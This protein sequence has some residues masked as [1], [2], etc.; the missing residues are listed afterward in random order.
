MFSPSPAGENEA[1]PFEIMLKCRNKRIEIQQVMLA[2]GV[3]SPLNCIQS[4]T[5]NKTS[6]GVGFSLHS[7]YL[8][9]A[10]FSACLGRGLQMPQC[11][12]NGL[13]SSLNRFVK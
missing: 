2:D 4:K 6:E 10:Y 5:L 12:S 7:L 11:T 1:L 3:K 8:A 9:L 13:L